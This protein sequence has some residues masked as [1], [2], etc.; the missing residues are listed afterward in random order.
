MKNQHKNTPKEG[1]TAAL[2]LLT[3]DDQAYT[4]AHEDGGAC[5]WQRRTHSPWTG[6]KDDGASRKSWTS[7]PQKEKL[8][9]LLGGRRESGDILGP[10]SW[11][12][13]GFRSEHS[14]MEGPPGQGAPHL[15]RSPPDTKGPPSPG[16]ENFRGLPAP[17]S[18]TRKPT[19]GPSCP[20]S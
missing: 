19:G 4:A 20:T 1:Q 5:L 14:R 7:S 9:R 12:K 10:G 17:A 15:P 2:G 3:E 18:P 6:N 16:T 11:T 13:S 8:P